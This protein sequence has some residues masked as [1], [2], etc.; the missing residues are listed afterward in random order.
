MYPESLPYGISLIISSIITGG[1]AF[2]AF[3]KPT[4]RAAHVFGWLMC[5]LTEWSVLYTVELLT[6]TFAG[7]LLALKI[8]YIGISAVGPLWLALALTYTG[9]SNWLTQPRKL[10]IVI[11][12]AITV[13]LAFTNEMH[14]LIWIETSINP[15]GFPSL[16][17]KHGI[18]FWIHTVISYI[19]I[20]SG[21]ILY[22]NAYFGANHFQRRQIGIMVAGSLVPVIGNVVYLSG[23]LPVDGM[24]LTPFGF[25]ISGPLLMWGLF[26]FNLLD[27]QPIAASVV[28]ENLHDAVVVLDNSKRIVD[29]NFVARQW[30]CV[31]D[32]AIGQ[33]ALNVLHPPDI[34][35]QV[36]DIHESQVQ[37]EVGEGEQRRWYHTEISPLKNSRGDILGHVIL[38]RDNTQEQ[39]LLL[40]E[41]KRTRMA[42]LLNE[43]TRASI[44]TADFRQ[45]LQKMADRL[46]E[47][48][49]ADGTFIT[50]W[51]ETEKRTVPA[52]AYGEFRDVYPKTRL[53]PDENTLTASVLREKR[54]IPVEDVFNTPYMNP[55]LASDVPTRSVL[56]LPLIAHDK[57]MGAVLIT[58]DQHRKFTE[59][60]VE[61]GEQ[62]AEQ[63]ALT[64]Y[65]ANLV[66]AEHRH[67]IQLSLLEEVGRQI[68][69][70]LDEAE[71]LHSTINAVVN[72]FGHAEVA[73]SL[74]VNNDSLEV[75]AINGTQDFGYQKGYQQKMGQGIIGY[76]AK[77]RQP[78]VSGDVSKDPYYISTAERN[79]SALGVPILNND[80]LFGVMYLES[81]SQDEFKP[82]DVQTIQTLANQVAISLQKARLH[83]RTQEHLRVMTTLQ[84]ISQTLASSLELNELLHNVI[85]LLKDNFGY[86]YISIY[87]LENDT[88]HLGAQVGYPDEV[89]IRK[90]PIATGITGQAVRTK[91]TQFL[92]DVTVNPSFLRASNE[93]NSEI[94]VPIL[95]HENVLGV[96]NVESNSRVPLNEND[97]NLLNTLA[98]TVAV[99][100][101]NAQLHGQVKA[102][103]ITDAVTGLYNRHAFEDFLSTEV[104]RADRYGHSLSLIVF[105][106]D[107]FKQYNDTWGHPAGDTRLKAI[108]D[109]IR[110]TQR[111]HDI[112]ARYGGDEFAIIL[113]NTDLE[114]AKKFA[115]RL[116]ETARD[117]APELATDGHSVSGYTLSIGFATYPN[118][119]DTFEKILHVADQAELAAKK[120]GKNRIIAAHQIT[121]L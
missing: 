113:P 31:G 90:I 44:E 91:Q 5:A 82:E 110:M 51:D 68:A 37:L 15:L 108:A 43:I 60:E 67:T 74:L 42:E 23:M 109:L 19:F 89:I 52:A 120:L 96:L 57:K 3:Y 62:A 27:L 45:M 77:T 121:I 105:D 97:V 24:D 64:I 118:D 9:R 18:W 111:K 63:I 80:N 69:N 33:N 98:G 75:A 95:K 115:R 85:I 28:V 88:L 6:P 79:G 7:K 72:K 32:E 61:T 114:G 34:I 35:R 2:Y 11:P 59:E 22:L 99:A 81:T 66:E 71:I 46:G 14:N 70:S 53:E 93:V 73:I 102:M 48:L 76:V 55:E 87:L 94:C 106:I 20:A 41:Q 65:K 119:G 38:A 54:T 29:M 117:A 26:Q 92:P 84:S 107:S 13:F 21:I 12:A 8:E 58:F 83:A 30:L 16:V 103:A 100:I 78:Y 47:L 40:A 104:K 10:L 86:T 116:L 50:M 112:A 36:Q 101:D 17:V 25:A 49:D 56:A 4:Q 1:L 39:K